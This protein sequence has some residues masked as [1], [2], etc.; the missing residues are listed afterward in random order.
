MSPVCVCLC[1]S[2]SPEII[3]NIKLIFFIFSQI[4]QDKNHLKRWLSK[5][6]SSFCQKK[7]EPSRYDMQF[8]FL[9]SKNDFYQHGHFFIDDKW[10]V[11]SVEK[12]W[13][14]KFPKNLINKMMRNDDAFFIDLN[15]NLVVVVVRDVFFSKITKLI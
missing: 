1:L 4:C 10:Q 14:V 12:N 3:I 9:N 2:L 15:L 5:W 7:R 8:F 11:Q 13:Q 6:W